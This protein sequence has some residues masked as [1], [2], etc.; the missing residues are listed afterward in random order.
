MELGKPSVYSLC[1]LQYAKKLFQI[2]HDGLW[3]NCT[4]PLSRLIWRTRR[5]SF[6]CTRQGRKC[7]ILIKK[8]VLLRNR[9]RQPKRLFGR[10]LDTK[11]SQISICQQT[12]KSL[13]RLLVA[14]LNSEF[15]FEDAVVTYFLPAPL[16][17]PFENDSI[18]TVTLK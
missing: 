11:L 4:S 5:F 14:F 9:K 13:R 16:R 2:Q 10:R 12:I 6:T 7:G 15:D 18:P 3:T 1:T 17:K 8:I